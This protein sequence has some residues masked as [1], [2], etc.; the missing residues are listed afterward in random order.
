MKRL[1][2]IPAVLA[3]AAAVV[4]AGCGSSNNGDK[5]AT[6]APASSAPATPAG[7]AGSSID[8]GKTGVGKVL[9]DS[10]GRT[11]YLFEADKRDKSNCSGACLSIWPAF[12]ASGKPVVKD[13]AAAAKVGTIPAAGGK[14]QV[15]YN[16]HPLYYYVGDRN[17]G[18]TSGQGLDQ[19]GAEW[20]VLNT[21]GSKIDNG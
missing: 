5:A 1:L 12:T 19:F 17:A 20:Y 14:S 3:I 21:A 9:V 13:G 16:G 18:D 15:T 7:A 11:L 6:A 8:V 10:K 4:I 2:S